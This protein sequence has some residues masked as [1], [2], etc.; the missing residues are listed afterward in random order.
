MSGTRTP[1]IIDG[2]L[3]EVRE[4]LNALPDQGQRAHVILWVEP[5]QS[6][7]ANA[8]SDKQASDAIAYLTERLRT[9][10]TDPE[11]IREAEAERAELHHSLNRNRIEADE[12]PLLP[13]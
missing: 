2:T 10:L 11:A 9:A 12:R 4:R 5:I 6:E 3:D 1:Q 7:N 13:E 8:V